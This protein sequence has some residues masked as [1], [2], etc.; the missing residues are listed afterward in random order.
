MDG[1]VEGKFQLRSTGVARAGSTR[2]LNR[3]LLWDKGL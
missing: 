2:V 1:A 3:S